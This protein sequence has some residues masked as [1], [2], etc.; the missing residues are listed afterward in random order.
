MLK[1]IGLT[2]GKKLLV[3]FISAV[4][5]TIPLGYVY[6]SVAIILFVLYSILAAKKGDLNIRFSLLLPILL[7]ILMALSLSWSIDVKSTLKALSKE[8]SL[9]FIPIAFCLNRHLLRKS[10]TQILNN[11]GTGMCIYA[12]YFLARA[13]VRYIGT[14]DINVFF[15]HELATNNINAIYLSALVSLALFVLLAKQRKR[16]WTY[17]AMVFLTGFL[18]LLSSKTIIIINVLLIIGYYLFSSGLSVKARAA[19]VLLFVAFVGVAGY[20]GKIRERLA[21][22]LNPNVKEVS[23]GTGPRSVTIYEAWILPTFTANDYFNGAAFRVYQIRIFTEMLNEDPIFFTGY[24]LNASQAKR[25][26][27]G[28]EHKVYQSADDKENYSKMNFHN[29]YVDIFAELGVFGFTLLVLMLSVNLKNAFRNKDFVHIAFA[30]VMIALFLTESFLWRQRGVVFFTVFYC[31]FNGILPKGT[32][33]ERHE[34]N[35]NNGGRR[36]FGITFM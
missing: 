36:L 2:P 10:V 35:I 4:A 33:I 25:E 20:N 26:A 31:L 9:L 17:V 24:G 27:K 14:G 8:A 29:Q 11:Y 34:K 22:E 13:V 5:L 6:N 7:F 16:F 19:S 12:F 23:A 3:F 28:I 21:E 1:K 32:D 30:I 15:Y 18:L